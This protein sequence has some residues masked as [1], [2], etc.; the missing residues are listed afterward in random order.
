MDAQS[1]GGFDGDIDFKSKMGGLIDSIFGGYTIEEFDGGDDTPVI[2]EST[3]PVVTEPIKAVVAPP[4]ITESTTPVVT[5]PIKSVVVTSP[6]VIESTPQVVTSP[7]VIESTPQVVTSPVVTEPIKSVVAPSVVTEPI[8]SVVTE[9]VVKTG[10]GKQQMYMEKNNELV[11]GELSFFNLG[12]P[13]YPVNISDILIY[14][15]D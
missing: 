14:I 6:V 2:T 3:T 5:E 12:K 13:K 7:V 9:P 11:I 1:G 8:K 4:V 15:E 10:S